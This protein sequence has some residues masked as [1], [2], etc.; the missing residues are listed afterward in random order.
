MCA[1]SGV[2]SDRMA[3]DSRQRA[4]QH[5]S[6]IQRHRGPDGE[7]CWSD[8]RASLG[9]RRL[10]IIDLSASGLQPMTNEDGTIVLVCNGEI[11]NFAELRTRL[12]ERGH[13]FKSK[14]DIEVILHLYEESGDDCVRH[15]V[16][17]FAF[18]LWDARRKRLLLGRDRV[19]EKPLYYARAQGGLAFASEIAALLNVPGVDAAP[20]EEA[21]ASW[22]IYPSSP[23]PL[24]PFAGIRA[25]PPAARLV[26]DGQ[27]RVERYWSIDCSRKLRIGEA[28]AAEELDLL[29]GQAVRGTLISDVP[30]GVLL[31]GG[32][33]SGAIAL[34]AARMGA[35][36]QA[37]TVAY[38]S[39]S[40]PDPDLAR[41]RD[42]AS[43]LNLLHREIPF[44]PLDLSR[45]PGIVQRYAQ[46]FNVFPM[47]Y[48]DQLAAGVRRQVTVALGGNGAD[49][50]LGGYRG[51]NRQLIASRMGAL[52]SRIPRWAAAAA[53]FG[54][55]RLSRLQSAAQAPVANRRALA[56]DALARYL[57]AALFT[58]A[59]ASR[60]RSFSPG[61]FVADYARECHASEYLDTVMYSDLM[62]YHQHGTTV[63]T[64]VSGM[65][66]S[67][68]I[69]A[70]FL[71]HRLLEFAFSLPRELKI[72][73]ALRPNL[74]KYLLKRTLSGKLP[75]G[76]LYGRKFGFG[77]NIR[78]ED[79][80]R[81]P[82]RAAV[83]AF[84]R[85]GRYLEL[86]FL[87]SRGAEWAIEHTPAEAWRLLV[88]AIWAELYLYGE[89]PEGIAS[90]INA[91]LVASAQ[92]RV[93]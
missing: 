20:D 1:I 90:R 80:L 40:H 24:T 5:M 23:A 6:D 44:V 92:K 18:G 10:A 27:V 7:G 12:I 68:E 77:Y 59:F 9:H 74:N 48:A 4:V 78:L 32:V 71:D 47:L 60:A 67:L 73:S 83:D 3:P 36:V 70:P 84:V 30:V 55:G 8:D 26:F 61:R 17:M 21:L 57:S 43:Q 15:L 79:L 41:A 22:L 51:Y 81:G 66:H 86:G 39:P 91:T 31:S 33:D 64:D 19:G 52:F 75:R 35:E 34:H 88:F 14:T 89:S 29:I 42:V 82:W 72:R 2:V 53:P 38:D 76:V 45:L 49:E 37:F 93:A 62:V 46:P 25:I 63:I 50:A 87:S 28:E 85:R 65:S 56:L 16:G 54:A 13:R 11:Y 58:P 69:R